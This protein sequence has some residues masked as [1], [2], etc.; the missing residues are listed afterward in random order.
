VRALQSIAALPS[1]PTVEV[2]WTAADDLS[3]EFSLTL[4][5]SAPVW[6]AYA[7]S[8]AVITFAAD[9]SAAGVYTLQAASGGITKNQTIDVKPAVVP[10]VLFVVP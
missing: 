4:P 5:V 6:A 8:P 9:D 7:P 1:A 2:A 3:G 10:P